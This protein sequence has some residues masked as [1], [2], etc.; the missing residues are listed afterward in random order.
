MKNAI[1]FIIFFLALPSYSFPEEPADS[2]KNNPPGE[3]I[4]KGWNGLPLPSI[5]YN[6]DI[7]FQY[8]LL[9]DYYYYGKGDIYPVYYHNIYAEVSRTTKGGGINQLFYD[10][11]NLFKKIRL[12][13]YVNYFTEKALD[14]YGF[15]G[16][17]SVYNRPWT[18][19]KQDSAIYKSRM[20]YRY[21]RKL[22][23][24]SAD[25]QGRFFANHLNWLAGFAFNET[26]IKKVDVGNL[27]KGKKE[28][29]KLPDIP[30]LYDEYVAWNILKPEERS[31]GMNNYVKLGLIYDTRDNEPN[32]MKGVWTE[33][34]FVIAPGFIGDG[35][36]SFVKL[37]V[38]HRQYF[39]LVKDRLSFVYRLGYQG[40]IAGSAPFYVQPVIISSYAKTTTI[41]GLGGSRT[42]RGILRNR[43]VGDGIAYGTLE[44]RWKF[45]KFL[46]FRQNF[47]LALNAFS[48]AGMVV[49]RISLDKSG[50]PDTVNQSVYFS[51]GHESPHVAFGAG[52]RIVMNQNIVI[53]ADYGHVLDKR[54]GS[55]GIYVGIGYLF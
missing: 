12:T 40:T 9:A 52:F 26:W 25:F 6:N 23:T 22:L 45:V 21:E 37:S 47:Y 15:N 36:F 41:D 46:L 33:V 49:Q 18:D 38:V 8:G 27:N 13:A 19:D 39:T 10:A 48:D 5:A 28:S 31:G 17:E 50:I 34:I 11:P 43:V 7:G 30:G 44:F 16:Y 3:K 32:P 2:S 35:H 42:I 53:C 29:K 20:Y 54:D 14:F 51:S 24:I 4:K 1:L 55:D